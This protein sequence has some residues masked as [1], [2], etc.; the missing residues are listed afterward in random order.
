MKKIIS[1]ILFVSIAQQLIAQT[2]TFDIATYRPPNDWKKEANNKVTTYTNINTTTGS[3]CVLAIYASTIS[4]GDAQKDFKSDWED[5]VANP[6]KAEANPKTETQITTDGWKAVSAAAPIKMEGLD[7]YAIL[8]VFSGFGKKLSVLSELNDQSYGNAI[9]SFLMTMKL[10]KTGKTIVTQPTTP[11]TN[12]TN[13]TNNAINTNNT[14][15]QF[16]LLVYTLPNGWNAKKYSDGDIV[17]PVDLPQNEVL[18]IWVQPSMNFSGT[19]E[20]ALQKSFDETVTQLKATKMNEVNGGNYSAQAVKKSFKG[21]EYIRCSGGIHMGGGDYPPEYGL[22]LFVIRINGRFE[23]VSILK[24]RK[25]CN[26]STY[27]PSDR[28]KYFNDIESFLFSLKFTDWK[29]PVVKTGSIKGDGITG[30]WQGLGL[31][32]GMAKP[33]ASL[34]AEIKVKQAIFFSNGQAYFG[35]KFPTEGLDELDTWM[36]AELNR[37]DWGTYTFS[38]GKGVLKLAYGDIPLKM[39][40]NKLVITANN[41]AHGY[42][43]INTVDGARFNG[44][45]A[46]SSKDFAGQETGKTP[47]I[48]FT[49]DG[50]FTDKG[51]MS[52][53]YHEYNDCLNAAKAPGSGTYEVENYSVIF[54]YTDGRKIKIAFLGTDYDKKNQSPATIT[55]SSNEDTMRRQ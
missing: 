19:M 20:Q 45:Y 41:T 37:R 24:S 26:Y 40:N 38:S 53:M 13:S 42:I 55:M 36:R 9:D 16:G 46:F 6:Y 4:L 34:G 50:K 30:V 7:A 31:S 44:N 17:T 33:G 43:K 21:W 10:D 52:I 3:F 49:A 54:N 51:A 29:E 35:P 15:S 47:L 48:S 12:N 22:D 32:V 14:K 18:N 1:F 25:N 23:K 11:T 5:L 8:T 28:L 39:E 27:Y 2:E